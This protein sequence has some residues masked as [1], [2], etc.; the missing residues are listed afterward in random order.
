MRRELDALDTVFDV[1][2]VGGGVYG[3]CIA[4]LAAQSGRSVALLERDDFGADVSHNSLKIVHGGFRYIQHFD[5]PRI[6][7]SV[8]AQRAWLR[9]AP[10]LVRP[11]RCV[12]PAYGYGT[13][14]PIAF[15]A[16]V[17]AFQVVAG[18]RN[19]GVP[20]VSRLPRSGVLSRRALLSR[21]PDL[22]RHDVSG[23]A[24]WYDAQMM[25]A[26]RLTF[27]CIRDA[28][29]HGAVVANH[30]E[31]LQLRASGDRV[32]GVAARD[33]LSGRQFDVR[34]RV[35]INATGPSV[36]RLLSNGGPALK[37]RPFVWTR[38]VNVVVRKVFDTEDAVGVGSRRPSDAAI[39]RSQR[40]F[41]VTPW[42]DCSVVGTSHI[43]H[44]P[45]EDF[46]A[47]V[48]ADVVGF[49][50]EVNSAL[51]RLGLEKDDLCY[52]HRGLTPAEDEVERSKRSTV[53]E[54]ASADGVS[55]LISV[56]GIKYTTAPIVAGAVM[57]AIARTL[58]GSAA[59]SAAFSRPLP[60]NAGSN[61][62][63]AF[64]LDA[65]AGD[66]L[67][68]AQRYGTNAAALF[69]VLPRGSLPSDEHVFRCRVLFGIENEMALRLRD[70]V[71]RV[72]DLAERGRLTADQLEWCADTMAEKLG[73]DAQRRTAEI[74]DVNTRLRAALQGEVA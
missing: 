43:E 46:D 25:D 48:D 36:E 26:N 27:E 23:G 51:P 45:D 74:G 21:Y 32:D 28:H 6:R 31:A 19:R 72:T 41:F 37:Q 8:A 64:H 73:W 39:G 58:G 63:A 10:H 65:D 67:W 57:T 62:G 66:S 22:E 9:A 18:R 12:I 56:L 30:V 42:Q 55:G 24:Y 13:R 47:A 20:A 53:I 70:A 5:L 17:A 52:V 71:F 50:D 11:M 68:A 69:D 34:A 60:G 15:A 29:D 44:R 1:L 33:R 40:L 35:T 54:H 2:V 38:N 4:R 7:E 61:R 49:L 59:R 16:G 3:A 14:G